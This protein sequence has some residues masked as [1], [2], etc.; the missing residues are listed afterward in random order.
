MR[1]RNST[2]GHLGGHLN[3]TH[4]DLGSLEFL[5]E[6]FGIK[7]MLDIGCGPGEQILKAE[8]IG[9]KSQGIDGWPGPKRLAE[10]IIIHD[11]EKGSYDHEE[12][13][14]LAWSVEFLEHVYEQYIPN[15]MRSFQACTYALVTHA[16][17]GKL[18]FHHVN[19]QNPDYWIKK[20]SEYGFVRDEDITSKVR[21]ASSMSRNFVRD[22]GIFFIK[23]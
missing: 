23:E 14:D 12:K 6:T 4:I 19:C 2:N 1:A 18:G 20:F 17:P 10:N 11:F 21:E 8:E 7:S 15:Y 22:N 16:P 9:I 5:K 13:Y 3:K